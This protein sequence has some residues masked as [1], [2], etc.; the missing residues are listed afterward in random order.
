MKN[1]IKKKNSKALWFLIFF[2]WELAC[3]TFTSA[4]LQ[5]SR[6]LKKT[7]Q[8]TSDS[9]IKT[10]WSLFRHDQIKSVQH[11]WS[12]Y[13]G[14]VVWWE[15]SPQTQEGTRGE[16]DRS[17]PP[18]CRELDS[19]WPSDPAQRVRMQG[20]KRR[21]RRRGIRRRGVERR[22]RGT[23]LSQS[24]VM[25]LNPNSNGPVRGPPLWV[26]LPVRDRHMRGEAQ[27]N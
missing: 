25:L 20:R 3:H 19:G 12:R 6:P 18:V 4:A 16:L 14:Y 2:Y 15:E 27:A 10:Q 11:I 1:I 5:S 22:R 23:G 9:N 13:E 7:Y 8:V 24:I 26:L 17:R 21:R